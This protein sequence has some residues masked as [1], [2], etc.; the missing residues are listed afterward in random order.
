MQIL[1]EHDNIPF[2]TIIHTYYVFNYFGEEK[3]F[4]CF[5]HLVSFQTIDV[6]IIPTPFR[7]PL[8]IAYQ[9]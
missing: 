2:R 5:T 3:A 9:I 4:M 8:W 1:L 7:N 6:R